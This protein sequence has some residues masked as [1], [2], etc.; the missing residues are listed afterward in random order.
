MLTPPTATLT[1][2]L[3]IYPEPAGEGPAW[4]DA[5]NLWLDSRPTSNTRRAYRKA[6]DLFLAF[7]ARSPFVGGFGVSG[8]AA[9]G[10]SLDR[11]LRFPSSTT[12]AAGHASTSA[13]AAA[14]RAN[15]SRRLRERGDIE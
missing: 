9:S 5:F 11:R 15:A 10:G 4:A 6:W 7:T 2:S 12:A 3:E 13:D 1:S 14:E 8:A